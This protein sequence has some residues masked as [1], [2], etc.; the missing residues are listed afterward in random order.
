VLVMAAAHTL[1][2]GIADK[3]VRVAVQGTLDKAMVHGVQQT[4]KTSG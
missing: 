1:A 4:M 3:E 2:G